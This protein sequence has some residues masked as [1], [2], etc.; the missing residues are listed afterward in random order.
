MK[1]SIV[2]SD[3]KKMEVLPAGDILRLE[4]H[5]MY[6]VIFTK[7]KREIV[8]T[9]PLKILLDQ[10]NPQIF[11]RVHKSHVVNL[12]AVKIYE[13]GRGGNIIMVDGSII[14]VSQR[15]KKKFLLRLCNK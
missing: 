2:I 15:E 8:Y 7:S 11:F 12:T 13:K 3:N 14:P 10:L 9:K 5:R 4:A 6:A 1:D